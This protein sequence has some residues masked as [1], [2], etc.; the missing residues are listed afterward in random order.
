MSR[1]WRLETG[2]T[3]FDIEKYF[4]EESYS[5]QSLPMQIRGRVLGLDEVAGNINVAEDDV[6]LYEIQYSEYLKENNYFAFMPKEKKKLKK[7]RNKNFN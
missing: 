2:E 4:L 5:L 3:I 7:I 1:L 6:L